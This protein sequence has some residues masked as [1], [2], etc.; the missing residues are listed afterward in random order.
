[1]KTVN[2]FLF[3]IIIAATTLLSSCNLAGQGVPNGVRYSSTAWIPKAVL[4]QAKLADSNFLWDKNGKRY[5]ALAADAD[6]NGTLDPYQDALGV[7]N[8]MGMD[9]NLAYDMI[10]NP[11]NYQAYT[12][13]SGGIEYKVTITTYSNFKLSDVNPMA[14]TGTTQTATEQYAVTMKPE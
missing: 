9:Y 1:M 12:N 6:G 11:Q 3:A 7:T 2:M 10:H 5:V 14:T 4:T 13:P 8:V